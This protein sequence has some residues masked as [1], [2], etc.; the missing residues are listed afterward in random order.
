MYTHITLLGVRMH[1]ISGVVKCW[2]RQGLM[3]NDAWMKSG[4]VCFLKTLVRCCSLHLEP[5]WHVVSSLSLS[6]YWTFC[7]CFLVLQVV[8]CGLLAPLTPFPRGSIFALLPLSSIYLGDQ[9]QLMSK[10]HYLAS[11]VHLRK[12]LK[13][14]PLVNEEITESYPIDLQVIHIA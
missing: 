9:R 1:K 10:L 5:Q 14:N 3:H 6:F 13:D 7:L 4:K 12:E 11:I 8:D 2:G